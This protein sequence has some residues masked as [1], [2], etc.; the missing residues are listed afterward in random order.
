MK[1]ATES[2]SPGRVAG[3]YIFRTV[4]LAWQFYVFLSAGHVQLSN[5]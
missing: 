4:H 5:G 2:A 3:E 1:V